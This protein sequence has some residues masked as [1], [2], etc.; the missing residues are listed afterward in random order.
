[1]ISRMTNDCFRFAKNGDIK[2]VSRILD[3]L[4]LNIACDSKGNTLLHIAAHLSDQQLA[5]FLINKGFTLD[6]KNND[7]LTPRNISELNNDTAMQIYLLKK[8]SNE[9]LLNAIIVGDLDNFHKSLSYGADL[10]RVIRLKPFIGAYLLHYMAFYNRA[11]LIEYLC[12]NFSID[13]DCQDQAMKET[14]LHTAAQNNHSTVIDILLKYNAGINNKDVMDWTP[15]HRA[16]INGSAKATAALLKHG[17]MVNTK[18][19][20]GYTPMHSALKNHNYAILPLL[21]KAQA[22]L[23]AINNFGESITDIAKQIG[24]NLNNFVL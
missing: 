12:S 1:M 4:G 13:I 2:N 7:G 3:L 19:I 18:D 10:Q 16:A 20:M 14:P 17:S 22:D 11:Q 5:E 23:T 21:L 15:L 9:M 8:E 6:V 24:I